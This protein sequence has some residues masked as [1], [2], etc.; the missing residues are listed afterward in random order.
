[1]LFLLVPVLLLLLGWCP[2]GSDARQSDRTPPSPPLSPP[3][4]SCWSLAPC[5]EQDQ[6][7]EVLNVWARLGFF[8][9]P[10]EHCIFQP[11]HAK[12]LAEEV[13]NCNAGI[14]A[15]R[16]AEARPSTLRTAERPGVPDSQAWGRCQHCAYGPGAPSDSQAGWV[17]WGAPASSSAPAASVSV[18]VSV[19]ASRSAWGEF[20]HSSRNDRLHVHLLRRAPGPQHWDWA[21]VLVVS[22]PVFVLPVLTVHPGHVLVDVLEQVH[23]SMLTSYG[24]VRRD[25]LLLLDVAGEAE[26]GV[27][28]E[29]LLQ[30]T[31]AHVRREVGGKGRTRGPYAHGEAGEAFLDTYG[32]YLSS[33]TQ[34]PVLT[35]ASLAE[36]AAAG[37]PVV[38]ADV[39]LG[40]DS[41][42]AHLPAA[43]SVAGLAGGDLLASGSR[44]GAGAGTQPGDIAASRN[45]RALRRHVVSHLA[46]PQRTEAEPRM[47][48]LVQRSGPPTCLGDASSSCAPRPSRA[49][50]NLG[51]V[52][53][54]LRWALCVPEEGGSLGER[55]S[56]H[57]AGARGNWV[58]LVAYFEKIPHEEQRRLLA[59]ASLLVTVAGTAAHNALVMTPPAGVLV[60]MQPDWCPYS[61]MYTAQ[62]LLLGLS[63]EALCSGSVVSAGVG[64]HT[65][66]DV[67]PPQEVRQASRKMWVQPPRLTKDADIRVDAPA[68]LR[69]LAR[70]AEAAS[71]PHAV[72][73]AAQWEKSFAR[74]QS[75]LSLGG[76]RTS[77]TSG[78]WEGLGRD[79]S[80]AGGVAKGD[81]KTSS[82][83]A[84]APRETQWTLAMPVVT[85]A[86][87][88]PLGDGKWEVSIR[89]ELKL[90]TGS[91]GGAAVLAA[92]PALSVCANAPLT[93]SASPW[94]TP[95]EVLN[96][97]SELKLR[98][99]S[100]ALSLMVWLQSS[101]H[102]GR[103]R[104][105]AVPVVLDV[106]MANCGVLPAETL[107]LPANIFAKPLSVF[108]DNGVKTSFSFSTGINLQEDMSHLCLRQKMS[109]S[110][111]VL[112]TANLY[113]Y[114][115]AM[116][117]QAKGRTIPLP[118]THTPS[119]TRPFVFMHIEKTAGSS[120]RKVLA[121]A[122]ESH[123]LRYFIPCHGGAE[124]TGGYVHCTVMAPGDVRR[125][126]NGSE[127]QL[128]N[129][130]V[131]G[132]HFEW[133]AWEELHSEAP[134]S[135]PGKNLN[136]PN[137]TMGN[138][139][140][141][142]ANDGSA[143]SFSC[144]TFSR[145]P[146]ERAISYYYQRCFNESACVGYQRRMND[147]TAE[148]LTRV[149]HLHRMALPDP[150][151][152]SRVIVLDDGMSD[153]A[154][155][156]F[157]QGRE[158]SGR[159]L[160]ASGGGGSIATQ[161]ISAA[162]QQAALQHAQQCV[163]GL[164]D[165]WDDSMRHVA[166]YFPWLARHVSSLLGAEAP[167]LM[168]LYTGKES[169][170]SLRQE[171]LDV[172]IAANRCD[173]ALFDQMKAQFAEQ[174]EIL[175]ISRMF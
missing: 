25:A 99:Q 105:T 78:T 83:A 11:V 12:T 144:F 154:C 103:L 59:Q 80:S 50:S 69:T 170:S 149:T 43:A 143:R 97:Y 64:R 55:L 41:S 71:A 68:L 104:G 94:C 60:L 14:E 73:D 98:T 92:M 147:L 138:T 74:Q 75:E 115:H 65:P 21:R 91:G 46:V 17:A 82:P 155:R 157:G 136:N 128:D 158:T 113:R 139:R 111:C 106:R 160:D 5:R 119:P 130:S 72:W 34:L 56:V 162:T 137:P 133:Q 148:E 22:R 168:Q 2:R 102:G 108:S 117:H 131:L 159:V 29:K 51:E 132:G 70:L 127:A 13:T 172:V 150:V 24:R 42:A 23:A 10:Q 151:N 67:T 145:H 15:Q 88:E 27:L 28:L 112:A 1:M 77:G 164:Q 169:R 9:H 152:A 52:S 6:P 81:T 62:P 166:H 122:A 96:Y 38:F 167:R 18:S 142:S 16:C 120:L 58:V 121:A 124:E 89:C 8:P 3:Q 93:T 48:L 53:S 31:G 163:V 123:G 141:K 7:S 140:K 135:I 79:A 45:L 76:S 125:Y 20:F 39:H 100:G 61:W 86:S 54:A 4:D 134:I 35:T 165:S 101:P 30:L 32:G 173:L 153:A 110:A 33:L 49:V 171:L 90:S 109:A 37:R 44:P 66:V 84:P 40:L 129:I 118:L 114:V 26:A 85:A 63:A 161:P 175:R 126:Q 174:E 116:Q 36:L 19:D 57:C 107:Q 47:L 87:A 156:A 95:L 146:V